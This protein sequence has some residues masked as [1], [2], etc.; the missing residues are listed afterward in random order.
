MYSEINDP[1]TNPTRSRFTA[2]IESG[3][4]ALSAVDVAPS[5]PRRMPF[6]SL[7]FRR[8][9]PSFTSSSTGSLGFVM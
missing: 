6:N 9:L 3:F 4:T 5:E 2:N 8:R 7:R 1:T